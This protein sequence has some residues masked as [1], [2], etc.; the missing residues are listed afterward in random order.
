MCTNLQ[1]QWTKNLGVTVTCVEMD[2]KTFFEQ[3]NACGYAMFR[4]GWSAD[5]DHPQDWFDSLFVSGAPSGGSCY[6]NPTVDKT[7]AG[8]DATNDPS[9]AGDY[10]AAGMD[11]ISD[12]AFAGLF[13]G[14]QEYLVHPYVK[15]AGGNALYDNYWTELRILRH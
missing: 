12:S 14:V 3:R 8:A 9:A 11:L 13:Y 1:Q 15:G 2:R 7:V 5:Y 6:S 4:Q 10:R